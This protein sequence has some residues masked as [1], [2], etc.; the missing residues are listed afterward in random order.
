MCGIEFGVQI[1]D[2]VVVLT[3]APSEDFIAQVIQNKQQIWRGFDKCH[4]LAVG[5][6]K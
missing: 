1:I 3:K 2:F 6:S 4:T 5:G